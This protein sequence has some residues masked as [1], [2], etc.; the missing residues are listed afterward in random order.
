M[1]PE[2]LFEHMTCNQKAWLSK[3]SP[4]L[5]AVFANGN[6]DYSDNSW[7]EVSICKAL[8]M[9]FSKSVAKTRPLQHMWFLIVDEPNQMC[10]QLKTA[11]NVFHSDL[12]MIV[13]NSYLNSNGFFSWFSYLWQVHDK[14]NKSGCYEKPKGQ[15]WIMPIIVIKYTQQNPTYP[16]LKQLQLL[17]RTIN[18]LK[19]N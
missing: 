4:D 16:H 6:F 18:S 7:T 12:R 14:Q 13:V 15:H 3:F 9:F 17:V 19:I 5:T 10:L 2:N 1:F 11:I 8:R